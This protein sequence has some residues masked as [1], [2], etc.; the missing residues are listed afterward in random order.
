MGKVFSEILLCLV[1]LLLQEIFR[2]KSGMK[3]PLPILIPELVE[4]DAAP[5]E[6]VNRE[7]PLCSLL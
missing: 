4:Q 5:L 6:A 7:K 2:I 1:E 3:P